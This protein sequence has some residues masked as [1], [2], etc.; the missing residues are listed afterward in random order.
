MFKNYWVKSFITIIVFC[1][2]FT[3]SSVMPVSEKAY[4]ISSEEEVYDPYEEEDPWDDNTDLLRGTEVPV[5]KIYQSMI[6]YNISTGG[7]KYKGSGQCWGYAEKIRKLFGGGGRTKNVRKK[8]TKK[9]IYNALKNVRPG[10]HVRFGNSKSGSGNHSI[11]VYKVTKDR[12]YFSDANWGYANQINHY[13]MSLADF[14]NYHAYNY[15]LWYISPT[16]GFKT[17]SVKVITATYEK[18]NKVD[19]TWRPKTGAKSY[20]VYRAS[21]KNGKYKKIKTVKS[22]LYIDK[23]PLVG[24][25]YYKVKP[26]NGSM[27]SPKKAFNKLVTPTVRVKVTGEGYSKVSW[28]EVKGAKKYGIYEEYYEED[29]YKPHYKLI[30]TVTGNTY[31]V[32]ENLNYSIAIRALASKKKAHSGY[33]SLFVTRRAPQPKIISGGMDETDGSF[34]FNVSIPYSLSDFQQINLQLKRSE[35]KNGYYENVASI[36]AYS[37]TGNAD[38]EYYYEHQYDSTTFDPATSVFRISDT[39]WEENTTYYYKVVAYGEVYEGLDSPAFMVTTPERP[40]VE[41]QYGSGTVTR[42]LGGAPIKYEYD[43]VTYTRNLH[44]DDYYD[45]LYYEDED[46]QGYVVDQSGYMWYATYNA[47]GDWI[48]YGDYIGY[49]TDD[50]YDYDND[51]YYYDEDYNYDEDTDW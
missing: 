24:N 39:S 45:N 48:E 37:K 35:T 21:S 3:A 43:G 14:A 47:E 20:T 27:S 38:E 46:G 4:A 13:N 17:S 33:N 34:V 28:D 31:T 49:N 50:P 2:I 10:T 16:G 26:N 15:I 11:A 6:Q 30:T 32:K 9:N 40:A 23:N 44:F 29:D 41:V 1:L 12:I 22:P 51:N 18:E 19:V 42:Y 7:T 36:G 8:S 25:N 5:K